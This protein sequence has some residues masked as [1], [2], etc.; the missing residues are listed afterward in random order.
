MKQ[1]KRYITPVLLILLM[2]AW[3]GRSHIRNW[4]PPAMKFADKTLTTVDDNRKLSI[5]DLKDTVLI[6]SCFQ[7]WC[8]DCARETP[9]L[10]ELAAAV[11][12]P[13]FKIVYVTDENIERVNAFRNRFTSANILFTHSA[14]S[15]K[16]LGI[17]VFPTTYL[18]D[19]KGK[20]ITT[21]L[22]GYHWMKELSTIKK[23][24]TQ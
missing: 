13:V 11:N 12:S 5:N 6:V 14:A 23:L 1:F 22:E 17:S 4:F 7:T 9:V 8:I 15:M 2:A 19:K 16:E 3:A 21:K 20:I 10:N 24:I 18:L